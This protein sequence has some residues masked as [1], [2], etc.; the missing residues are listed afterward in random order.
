MG[1]P[2]LAQQLQKAVAEGDLTKIKNIADKISMQKETK[3]SKTK[4]KNKSKI[5][6]EVVDLEDIRP[7]DIVEIEND[8]IF[9]PGKK[10]SKT[11]TYI[12]KDGVSRTRAKVV[13]FKVVRNRSNEWVDQPTQTEV[14]LQKKKN[15]NLDKLPKKVRRQPIEK[16]KVKCSECRDDK[17]VWA[18]EVR[19]GYLFICEDC[20]NPHRRRG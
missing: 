15:K 17:E 3:P 16:I 6:T 7:G 18:T 13:P 10:E 12:D 20:L 2:T 4:P 5:K 1:R 11:E 19:N 8:C 9:R 14:A